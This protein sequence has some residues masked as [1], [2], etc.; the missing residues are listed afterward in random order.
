MVAVRVGVAVVLS[1]VVG[2]GE[3]TLTTTVSVDPKL[4]P[5]LSKIAQTPVNLPVL[6]GT[7]KLT[8]TS[9]VWPAATGVVNGTLVGPPINSP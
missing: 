6:L 8:E 1:V 9:T 5:L 2:L 3:P 7:V 4:T